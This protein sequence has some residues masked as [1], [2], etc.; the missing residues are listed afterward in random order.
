M[1]MVLSFSIELFIR[2]HVAHTV[3]ML[4]HIKTEMESAA[5][6]GQEIG[7]QILGELKNCPH[8]MKILK[9]FRKLHSYTAIG[10]LVTVFC[11]I[12]HINYLAEKLC[13]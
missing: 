2:F 7:R 10:T 11:S 12:Y 3:V 1:C 8:Y 9:R 13:L 5:G 6:N 4:K